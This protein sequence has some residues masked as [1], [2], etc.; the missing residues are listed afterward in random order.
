MYVITEKL[1]GSA[2]LNGLTFIDA[3]NDS[4]SSEY[5]TLK[6]GFCKQVCN[7]YWWKL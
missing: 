5:Q 3:Y 1:T 6:E 2:T 7:G 4:K